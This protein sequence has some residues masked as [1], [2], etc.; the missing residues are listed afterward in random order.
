MED[1]PFA[2]FAYNVTVNTSFFRLTFFLAIR[3][4]SERILFLHF[5]KSLRNSL[6][7]EDGDFSK[8]RGPR[9]SPLASHFVDCEGNER[10]HFLGV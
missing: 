5:V 6:L 4:K 10:F 1:R 2:Q 8:F 9:Y 3:L 7:F